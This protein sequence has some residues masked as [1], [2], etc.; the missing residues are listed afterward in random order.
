MISNKNIGFRITEG[1]YLRNDTYWGAKSLNLYILYHK[2]RFN[3][4]SFN[5]KKRKEKQQANAVHIYRK[6]IKPILM[7]EP[8]NKSSGRVY[9]KMT[10]CLK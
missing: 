6:Y 8:E 2:E 5:M 9:D 3:S 10:W 1:Y 7:K 4:P